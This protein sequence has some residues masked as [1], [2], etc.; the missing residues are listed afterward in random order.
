VPLVHLSL[1]ILAAAGGVALLLARAPRAALACAMAG[2]FGASAVAVFAAGGVLLGGPAGAAETVAWPL[3]LG[4]ARLALD[5]LSAWFLLTTGIVAG[6]VAIYSAAYMQPAAGRGAAAFGALLCALTSSLILVICA[7][8]AVLFLAGWEAMTLSAFFLVAFHHDRAEVRRGAWMYLVITHV[9]TA[10][11]VVPL[12]VAMAARAGTTD[13]GAFAVA[14]RSMPAG[15]L[16]ALFL[17]GLA[18]FGTKAGFLPVHVWLPAAHPVAP[19]PVSA[20]LSGVVVKSGIYGLLRL[21]QWLGPLPAACGEI[22][23]LVGA[24]GGVMGVLLALAQHDLKRLL[25]YHT[26][27]NIGIIAL[28]IGAGMLGQ[29]TGHATLAVLGY[30]GALLH[31]TNHALFKGL[32]FLS[33][34]AVLHG[35]GTVEIE[36][37]GGLAKR[38]P[39][40]AAL[41]LV[42]AVAICGL[43][44]LNGFVGEWVIF[45]S[46]FSGALRGSGASA[47]APAL[48]LV[49]LALMGGLAL[50]CFAKVFGVVFLGSPRD[51]GVVP[52]ATPG[53]MRVAMAALALACVLIGVFPGAWVA[54]VYRAAAGFI[55]PDAEP[56]NVAAGLHAVLAPARALTV[57][58]AVFAGVVLALAA[59]RR[60]ALARVAGRG[61]A[62]APE[63][64]WGC[65]Y[66][67]PTARMQ[68]TASSFAA[69]LVGSFR[70][71]L[72]PRR[73]VERPAGVFARG[74]RLETRATD[75]AER[76]LFEPLVRG[77]SRGLAMAR[78]VSW[79]G[80]GTRDGG[81]AAPAHGPARALLAAMVRGLRRGSI[82]VRLAFIVLTLV[83]LLAVEALSGRAGGEGLAA[84]P[85]PAAGARP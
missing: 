56:A 75:V 80:R 28:A 69:S 67:Q 63:A 4:A 15:A 13:F 47:A 85:A 39:V 41:F 83:V 29:A 14:A 81:P 72:W 74:G 84:P 62:H 51:P 36:R 21:L 19:T 38:T 70:V 24:A 17:L 1:G 78:T 16:V 8:D 42:G 35:T 59:L 66:A 18:G 23:I 57:A 50:A 30:A 34:G 61:G 71:L 45:G 5:G 82:Q 79:S 31:V 60:V 2:V 53:L 25:A 32:L 27:E 7:A 73:D 58:A 33:A 9:A 44:P 11:G 77:V 43:P 68:Y 64:T 48:G 6:T 55:R 40:N 12:L 10:L 65:G 54:L 22:L 46:L 26:V 3:P 37:L 49:S 52:H 76:D 20:L